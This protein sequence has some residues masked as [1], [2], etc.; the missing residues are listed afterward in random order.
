MNRSPLRLL[1]LIAA[2]ALSCVPAHA[3][4][5]VFAKDAP[6]ANMTKEDLDIAGATMRKAL[7]EGR[8]G[9]S[10]EWK[11]PSTSASGTVTALPRFEKDGLHC[12]GAAFSTEAK[13]KSGSSKWNL[14][15]TPEGWKVLE[16]RK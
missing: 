15:K 8:D 13:G 4:N 10:Y 6:I 5:E 16:G 9:Q 14:C 7:D 11:N 2:L 3:I 1:A 12:R